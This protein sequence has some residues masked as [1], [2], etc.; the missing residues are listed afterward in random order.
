MGPINIRLM[1]PVWAKLS[2]ITIPM[3]I[4]G[5]YRPT[6]RYFCAA[7][8]GR[9]FSRTCEPSRGGRGNRLKRPS[10]M[11]KSISQSNACRYTSRGKT[12]MRINTPAKNAIAMLASGPASDMMMTSLRVFLKYLISTGTGLAHPKLK[13]KRQIAPKMSMWHTGLNESLPIFFA[14]GSPNQSAVLPWA[15]SWIVIA[16]S[17]TGILTIHWIISKGI[18]DPFL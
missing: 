11:F 16:K 8:G 2:S 5:P 3:R 12:K 1:I 10:P 13:R 6:S 14:V 4:N 9:I 17:K 15:Y 18:R 7:A